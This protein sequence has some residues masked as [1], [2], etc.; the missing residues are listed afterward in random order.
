MAKPK[1]DTTQP[2]KMTV[3]VFQFEGND[4][5]LQEGLKMISAAVSRALPNHP[6][7]S[8]TI[9]AP[10]AATLVEN[11]D[12]AA[13][14]DQEQ[15][16]DFAGPAMAAAAKR[17]QRRTIKSPTILNLELGDGSVPLKEFLNNH[18]V[19]EISKRYLLIAYWLKLHL[20]LEEI[21]SDHIHTCF[22]YMGWHTPKDAI[23]P[24]RD[25]KSKQG[26]FHK[27]EERGYYKLN[28]VGENEV[29]KIIEGKA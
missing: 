25:M 11:I 20:T 1:T 17:T 23:Q 4:S 27:G 15:A 9:S 10:G 13:E 7:P 28:H 26:W 6:R 12:S 22:R 3:M 16:A 29:L 21:S 19:E 14:E 2:S 24:L 5:T 18:Q 8:L